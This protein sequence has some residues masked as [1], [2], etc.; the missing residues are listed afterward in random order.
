M[1]ATPCAPPCSN[2]SAAGRALVVRPLF[3][4]TGGVVVFS[5]GSVDAEAVP[6]GA[7]GGLGQP[8]G[9]ARLH[10]IVKSA[11]WQVMWECTGC[12]SPFGLAACNRPKKRRYE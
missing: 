4:L 5:G 1:S 11:P 2:E 10:G 6:V 12:H 9:A 3:K 7:V 8:A